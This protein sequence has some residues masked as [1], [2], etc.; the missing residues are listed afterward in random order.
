MAAPVLVAERPIDEWVV[1][2]DGRPGNFRVTGVARRLAAPNDPPIEVTLTP[3]YR[4]HGRTYSVYFDVLATP[5]F[6]RRL[7]TRD[8]ELARAQRLERATVALVH[9]GLPSDE[10][11]FNYQSDLSTRPVVRTGEHT[12]RGGSGWFSFRLPVEA[13]GEQ[14]VVVTYRNDLGLPVLANFEIQVD[15]ATLARYAANRSATGFWDATYPLPPSALAGKRE[16]TVRFLAGSE[17]RV[18]PVY[19]IRIVRTKDV[20]ADERH[21]M[22]HATGTSV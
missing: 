7:A 12:A 11:T 21:G 1:P 20:A 14:A 17:S 5:E 19:G 6:V 18:V 16:I 8:A 13:G 22:L 9:P 3:F 10:Q 2:A 15:G 4:T